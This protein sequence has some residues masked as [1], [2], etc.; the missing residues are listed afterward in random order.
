MTI[1]HH[2]DTEMKNIGQQ[3]EKNEAGTRRQWETMREKWEMERQNFWCSEKLWFQADPA[4]SLL[5]G[6]AYLNT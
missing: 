3:L 5:S 4:A 1:S 2:G 6:S